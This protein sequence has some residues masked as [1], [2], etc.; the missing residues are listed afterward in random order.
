SL[1]CAIVMIGLASFKDEPNGLSTH[2]TFLGPE[3]DMLPVD[4]F[5]SRTVAQS[6]QE[7]EQQ[8]TDDESRSNYDDDRSSDSGS[9]GDRS[10]W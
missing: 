5:R 8:A 9:D 2:S 6:Y 3:A 10:V 4:V 1:T 7:A